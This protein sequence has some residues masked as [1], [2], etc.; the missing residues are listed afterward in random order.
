MYPKFIR[1]GESAIGVDLVIIDD[2]IEPFAID[3]NGQRPKGAR[4]A[5]SRSIRDG[6]GADES[7][8]V[9]DFNA[10]RPLGAAESHN[11]LVRADE[12][13]IRSQLISCQKLSHI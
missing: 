12:S 7:T 5:T 10:V 3:R 4:A 6:T 9:P 1:V 11:I 2:K 8:K 13:V